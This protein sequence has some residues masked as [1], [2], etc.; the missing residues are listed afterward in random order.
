[1]AGSRVCKTCGALNAVDDASCSRCGQRFSV[2][3]AKALLGGLGAEPGTRLLLGLYVL[4]AF[5]VVASGPS[6]IPSVALNLPVRPVLSQLVRFG[7]IAPLLDAHWVSLA[8]LEPLRL[9]SATAVHADLL[10]LFFNGSFLASVGA[11]VEHTLGTGRFL[12]L[13][14]L[15]GAAGFALSEWTGWFPLTLGASGA[16]CGLVGFEVMVLALARDQNFRRQLGLS[17]GW[18]LLLTLAISRANHVAHF[19]GFFA[20]MALAPLVVWP[21]RRRWVEAAFGVVALLLL[22]ATVGGIAQAA[23]GPHW[24]PWR[25]LESQEE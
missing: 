24:V 15:T 1:M 20:G 6:P 12:T 22:C 10:H 8:T 9:L 11:R 21:S 14:L 17:L 7:A 13:Y 3:E 16:L 18:L 23:F 2:G 4:V 5:A 19:G 25:E